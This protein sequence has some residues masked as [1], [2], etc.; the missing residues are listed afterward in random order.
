VFDLYECS[1]TTRLNE[2]RKYDSYKK[3]LRFH[4]AL[5]IGGQ[6]L[7]GEL[8]LSSKAF[9]IPAPTAQQT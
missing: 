2:L 9:G 8:S 6:V 1:H 3:A 7:N 5:G 4:V